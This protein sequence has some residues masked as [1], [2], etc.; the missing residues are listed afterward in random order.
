MMLD[1]V[2]CHPFLPLDGLAAALGWSSGRTRRQRDDLVRR[3]LARLPRA[4]TNS[5]T[6]LELAELTADGL[7]LMA[8][9]LGFPLNVAVQVEGLAGGGPDE[10]IGSRQSLAKNL[11][12]TLGADAVFTHLY[13]LAARRD[14]RGSDDELVL[15]NGPGACSRGRMR[16]DGHGVYRR[17]DQHFH[18][19]LEYDRGT[20]GVRPLVR[21]LNAY[22]DYLETGRFRRDYPCF[23]IVLVVATSNPAETRFAKAARAASVGRYARLPLLLT[24]L[25]R[26]HDDPANS[27][28]LLGPIWR[29][30]DAP[31]EQR[32]HWIED[33]PVA[34]V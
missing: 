19:F 32:R 34:G 14:A 28:G 33:T 9:R 25:W 30:P 1:V 23:P 7:R 12:H 27:D 6:T 24:T 21:K 5:G 11:A 26:I 31:F 13:S 17:G 29:E 15:W 3:G 8:A 10:P 20:S 18:F 2:G 4:T 16:P 22:Y